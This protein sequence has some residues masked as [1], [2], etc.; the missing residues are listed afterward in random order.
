MKIGELGAAT[1]TKAETIRYYEKIGLLPRPTRSAANY[2]HMK[3]S[4]CSGWHSSN[5]PEAWACRWIK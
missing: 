1:G 3:K 5:V 4:I 2:R